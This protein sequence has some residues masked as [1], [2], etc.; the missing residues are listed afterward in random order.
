KRASAKSS[1]AT[2]GQLRASAVTV[3]WALWTSPTSL[4]RLPSIGLSNSGAPSTTNPCTLLRT[5]PTTCMT[6]C[7][8]QCIPPCLPPWMAWAAWTCGTSTTTPRCVGLGH[9]GCVFWLALFPVSVRASLV[10]WGLLLGLSPNRTT[11]HPKL[12]SSSHTHKIQDSPVGVSH[13]SRFKSDW[14][15]S[16]PPGSHPA[17]PLTFLQP[18]PNVQTTS[19][20]IFLPHRVPSEECTDVSETTSREPQPSVHSPMQIIM[21][22]RKLRPMVEF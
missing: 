15:T 16:S 2:R 6:S 5:M 1:R 4:L 20:T 14:V 7:G 3:Q 12:P 22:K 9:R 21:K 10:S 13:S 19:E 8:R 11:Q 17:T 18:L